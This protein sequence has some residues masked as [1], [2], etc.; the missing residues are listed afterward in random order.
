MCEHKCGLANCW[1]CTTYL[2]PVPCETAQSS[3]ISST[4]CHA[5]RWTSTAYGTV[6]GDRETGFNA[7][8][9]TAVN[10]SDDLNLNFVLRLSSVSE[11]KILLGLIQ[12]IKLCVHVVGRIV[13]IVCAG[14]YLRGRTLRDETHLVLLTLE[15][16]STVSAYLC[17]YSCQYCYRIKQKCCVFYSP[18]AFCVTQKV[19]KGVCGRGYTPDPA[20]EDPRPPS[21]LGRSQ[22]P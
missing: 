15:I 5:S 6:G 22:T 8:F 2:N 16:F 20:G 13:L 18:K 9:Q 14:L 11:L 19:L 10:L 4:L 21:Q 1:L 3:W 12:K 17:S 7:R